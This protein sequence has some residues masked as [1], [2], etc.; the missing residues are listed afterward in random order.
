MKANDEEEE[1]KKL[2]L[3]GEKL[4]QL[5]ISKGYGSYDFFAWEHRIPR[6]QYLKME[7]GKNYTMKSLF[8][9][10]KALDITF[11]EFFKGIK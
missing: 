3:I 10:L 11:E 6:M 2:K 9:V 4:R 5:R 1:D 7:Q 8:R